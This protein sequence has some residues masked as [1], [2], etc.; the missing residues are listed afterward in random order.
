MVKPLVRKIIKRKI[1][2][3]IHYKNKKYKHIK[4]QYTSKPLEGQSTANMD[5]IS[6]IKDNNTIV[7]TKQED[8]KPHIIHEKDIEDIK[9]HIE[10][11]K[12]DIKPNIEEDNKIPFSVDMKQYIKDHMKKSFNNMY[13]PI[14]E[15]TSDMHNKI[16]HIYNMNKEEKTSLFG[17]DKETIEDNKKLLYRIGKSAILSGSIAFAQMFS[18]AI[19]TLASIILSKYV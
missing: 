13:V 5:I 1:R 17:L 9:P 7:Q 11:N 8:I 14:K 18:P 6:N 2:K 10:E 15:H 3:R 12:E 4:N 19:G 16:L